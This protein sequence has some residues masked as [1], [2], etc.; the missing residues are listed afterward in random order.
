MRKV[1][2]SF[3]VNRF[4]KHISSIHFNSEIGSANSMEELAMKIKPLI[5]LIND[6]LALLTISDQVC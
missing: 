4:E 5:N 3:S 6:R 1:V 2:N